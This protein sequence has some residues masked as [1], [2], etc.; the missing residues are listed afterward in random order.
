MYLD[1]FGGTMKLAVAGVTLAAMTA[2]AALAQ[3]AVT[4]KWALWDW[5]KTA[6]YKP[7]IEAYQA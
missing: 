2:G 1:K 3:D 7:L 5:D 4:L 6:Y